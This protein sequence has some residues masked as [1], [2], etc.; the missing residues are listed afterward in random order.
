[1]TPIE[2]GTAETRLAICNP[3]GHLKWNPL[4]VG[5]IRRV[6][7]WIW[8]PAAFSLEIH[9]LLPLLK[10]VGIQTLQPNIISF[11]P[12][13]AAES[14]NFRLPETAFFTPW[15]AFQRHQLSLELCICT[16]TDSRPPAPSS[17][18]CGTW[19]CLQNMLN[20]RECG[21]GGDS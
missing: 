5:R 15:P 3:K 7:A 13:N 9:S 2:P 4:S 16:F 18:V 17:V 14:S 11:L 20:N 1:M 12:T 21:V 6:M 19:S 8:G 10:Y